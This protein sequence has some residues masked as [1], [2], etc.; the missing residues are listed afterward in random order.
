MALVRYDT[1]LRQLPRSELLLAPLRA[2]DA[3]VSSRMEGTISTLEEVLRLRPMPGKRVCR[4]APARR[5]WKSRST[6]GR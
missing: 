5:I 1:E 4:P 6:P 3:V 2:R